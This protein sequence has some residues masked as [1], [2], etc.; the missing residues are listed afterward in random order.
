MKLILN[1]AVINSLDGISMASDDTY[2]F[3]HMRGFAR[4]M[5]ETWPVSRLADSEA[6]YTH[7]I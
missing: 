3:A 1:R 6:V 5:K 2:Y 4:E 7:F